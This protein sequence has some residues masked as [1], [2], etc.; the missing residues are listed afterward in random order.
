VYY[1]FTRYS[2]LRPPI[3]IGIE[4]Y[5]RLLQDRVFLQSILNTVVY[6]FMYVPGK[7]VLALILALLLNA[8]FVKPRGLF[9]A[10]YYIPV[11]T[12]M[13]AASYIWIWIYQPDSGILNGLLGFIGIPQQQWIYA[14][15]SVLPSISMVTIWKD[16]G[17]SVVLFVAGLQSIPSHLYEAAIVEGANSW[18]RLWKITMPLLMP[19]FL[20]VLVT[21][22]I[23]SFQVFTAIIIMTQGGPAYAS[24][25]IVHQIYLN[26]FTYLHMGRASAMSFVLL[27]I[28]SVFSIPQFQRMRRNL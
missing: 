28:I 1:S 20:L 2:I 19:V 22:I 6:G 21:S 10:A 5:L 18:Q 23:M 17:M 24:T 25:T 14:S 11:I 27:I 15:G 26:A 4:N 13:A 8:R 9:L 12:S 16:F 3:W 7:I